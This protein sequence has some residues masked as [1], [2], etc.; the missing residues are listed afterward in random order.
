[1]KNTLYTY[2]LVSIDRVVDGDTIDAVV[3]LGFDVMKKVRIRLLGVDTP[4]V[5]TRNINEKIHGKAASKYVEDWVT[6]HSSGVFYLKSE[7][8]K[9][10]YG[11]VLGRVISVDNDSTHDLV[12]ELLS[13]DFQKRDD[14]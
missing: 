2:R 8:Y 9:G 6:N 4:E 12:E 5:R 13:N 1:M 10:K 7:S 11:R 3:D 14:Y